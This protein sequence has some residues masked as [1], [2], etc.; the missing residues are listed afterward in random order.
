LKSSKLPK[1]PA[2]QKINQLTQ[3]LSPEDDEAQNLK[4]D[5]ALQRLLRE[6][7]L[8]AEYATKEDPGRLRHLT[9]DSRISHLGGKEIAKGNVPLRIQKGIETAKAKRREKSE[10]EAQ[11]AGILM[12]VK[13]KSKPEKVR[14]R[15]LRTVSGVGKFKNGML[16]INAREIRRVNNAGSGKPHRGKSIKKLFK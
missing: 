13:R 15:G 10:R 8:L 6:S 1:A 3:E 4:H 5:I 14:E 7:N 16:K 9:L 11:E 2:S 12:P